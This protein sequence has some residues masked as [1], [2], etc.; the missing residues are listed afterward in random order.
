MKNGIVLAVHGSPPADFPKREIEEFF[1]LHARMEHASG[2]ERTAIMDRYSALEARIR[3]WPR[4][5]SNDP[6]HAGS[7]RIAE[8][9]ERVSGLPVI[10]GF[11]EF[12][13]PSLGE[14]LD[15]A[16]AAFKRVIVV[17]PMLTAGG[18]HAEFDIPA[19]IDRSRAR[20]PQTIFLY[21]WPFPVKEVAAFLAAQLDAFT[22][23]GDG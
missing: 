1:T 8:E 19:A 17:T 6:F 16:A 4:S 11:N 9:L 20:H 21:A 10:V 7:L 14:A 2:P 5:P 12:C 15:Q 3:N 18:E 13:I 23:E 22:Q